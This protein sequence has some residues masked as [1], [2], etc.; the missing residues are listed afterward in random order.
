MTFDHSRGETVRSP[1]DT[2]RGVRVSWPQGDADSVPYGSLCL[3]VC[4]YVC[5]YVY[6]YVE[7]ETLMQYHTVAYVCMYVCMYVCREGGRR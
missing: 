6:M 5:M 2:L 3:Y 1:A 7:R 4:M